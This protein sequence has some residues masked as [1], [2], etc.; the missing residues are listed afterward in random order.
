MNIRDFQDAKY[1]KIVTSTKS[2]SFGMVLVHSL[3]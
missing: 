2:I 1:A 3:F